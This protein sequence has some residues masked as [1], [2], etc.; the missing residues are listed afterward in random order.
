MSKNGSDSATRE[1]RLALVLYGGVSLA[2]YMHGITKELLKLVAASRALDVDPENNPFPA[3]TTDHV[4]WETLRD[5]SEVSGVRTR[6]VV[7][8]I[9]GTSAGGINGVYLAK[10]LAENLRQDELR[11]L[12]IGKGDIGILA[13][14]PVRVPFKARVGPLVVQS[15]FQ[16]SSNTPVLRG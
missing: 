10:A 16:C 3:Q 14:G 7:D 2:I 9:A 5:L 11:D 8:V 15:L 4:Y 13:R 12:W 6:V 1:L